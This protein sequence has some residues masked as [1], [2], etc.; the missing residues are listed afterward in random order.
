M[1]SQQGSSRL[2]DAARRV[3]AFAVVGTALPA[4][5]LAAAYTSG[6]VSTWWLELLLYV[7]FPAYLA[8]ALIALALSFLLGWRWRVAAAIGVVLV[9]TVIMGLVLAR[10]D[11]GSEPL[12]MMTYNVKSYQASFRDGGYEAI[13]REVARHDPDILV[14]QDADDLAR[15]RFERPARVAALFYGRQVYAHGQY[16]VVSKLPLRECRPEELPFVHRP[17]GYVRC[18]VNVHGRD[19]DLVTAHLISPRDGLNAARRERIDGIDDWQLNFA[20]REVQARKLAAD[21]A[22]RLR[23]LILAGDLNAPE[24][25]PVIGHLLRAGLRDAFS[26]AGWGYGFTHGHALKPRFSFLRIDH[27]LVSPEIGVTEAFPG[28]REASEHR[29]VIADLLLQRSR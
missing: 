22:P 5:L 12:R 7:P 10:G 27:I 18:I 19:I 26:S 14:M 16:I 28:G 3:A 2:R 20:E 23:P 8:P 6:A 13:I 25:S 9:A 11:S 17:A 21:V 15:V 24:A 29:P 1:Q 4:A